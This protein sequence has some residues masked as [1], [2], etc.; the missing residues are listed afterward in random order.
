MR[1][2]ELGIEIV[3]R[4]TAFDRFGEGEILGL[5][6]VQR[7]AEVA[8]AEIVNLKVASEHLGV[9][10]LAIAVE[11]RYVDDCVGGFV[12]V[13]IICDFVSRKTGTGSV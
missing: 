13:V 5:G 11:I 10:G 2:D 1:F 9:V 3:V 12:L 7:N 8:A 6:I 4:R